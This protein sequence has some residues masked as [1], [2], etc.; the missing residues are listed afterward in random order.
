MGDSHFISYSSYGPFDETRH[1]EKLVSR[2]REASKQANIATGQKNQQVNRLAEERL[3]HLRLVIAERRSNNLLSRQALRMLGK[4][5]L[6]SRAKKWALRQGS[7]DWPLF[8]VARRYEEEKPRTR[9]PEQRRGRMSTR[10]RIPA[11]A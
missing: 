9:P 3:A 2:E 4:K 8:P 10:R 5:R 6:K 1:R 11:A 7:I